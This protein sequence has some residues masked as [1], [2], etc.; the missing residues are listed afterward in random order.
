M[1]MS[2]AMSKTDLIEGMEEKT[3]EEIIN[4][5]A[6]EYGVDKNELKKHFELLKLDL[7]NKPKE[8]KIKKEKAKKKKSKR[9]SANKS[10]RNN[11]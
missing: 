10:K 5:V 8:M 11:R 3:D 7:E 6:E 9:K 2:K 4:E 1:T